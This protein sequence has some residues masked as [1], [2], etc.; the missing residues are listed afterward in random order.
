[1]AVPPIA[2]RSFRPR[3]RGLSPARAAEFE[4]DA[5]R[6]SIDEEGPELD[7]TA[8]FPDQRDVVLDIGFGGGEALIELAATRSDEAVIGVEI[9][10]PGVAR[11]VRAIEEHGWQHVRIS[12]ADVLDL[13]P[14]IPLASL[15]GIRLWF[16][17]PWPKPR[18]RH[19]RIVRLDVVSAW[20]DRLR[21]GGILHVA[22]DIDDYAAQV[23]SVVAGESRLRGGPIARPD[24]RPI[25]RF[26]SRGQ[27][28]GRSAT[29]LWYER[30]N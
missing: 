18:Q 9:H 30:V 8:M 7:L 10:T 16:P 22:T 27:A 13:L 5:P 24:W 29:D 11:V 12:R 14:R 6:W 4:R 19:R 26:E 25:T 17:D 3:R 15:A 20:T 1:M 28:E 2:A 21:L 23:E